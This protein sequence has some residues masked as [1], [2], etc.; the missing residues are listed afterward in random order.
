MKGIIYLARNKLNGKCYVGKTHKSLEEGKKRHQY[1][2]ENNRYASLLHNALRKY[3][4]DAFEW[5]VLCEYD[6]SDNGL[7]ELEKYYVILHDSFKKGYNLTKGADGS[8]GWIP[9]LETRKKR[10]ESLKG[11]CKGKKHYNYGK[12]LSDEHKRKLSE[13][14]TGKNNPMYG[15]HRSEKVKRKLSEANTG[16]K[17]P[18]Y[19]KHH[20]LKTRKIK[21]KIKHGQGLFGFTGILFHK[22]NNPE[23]KCWQS[24]IKF[25]D[26]V[27]SLGLY[28]DPYTASLVYKLVWNEIYKESEKI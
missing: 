1:D 3:G 27:K 28:N 4:K 9:S 16:E 17:H 22:N 8:N 21:S 18:F 23:V 14:F 19:G 13:A 25:R 10:S 5:K 26:N 6:G 11:K 2:A 7:G 20:S 12:H 15:K 24:R